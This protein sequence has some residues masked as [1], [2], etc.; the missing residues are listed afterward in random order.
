LDLNKVNHESEKKPIGQATNGVAEGNSAED[1]ENDEEEEAEV[2]TPDPE[3][4]F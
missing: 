1:D 2:G 4:K 3:G